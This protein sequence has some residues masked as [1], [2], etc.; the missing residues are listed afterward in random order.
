LTRAA[1]VVAL[2]VATP[3]VALGARAI[4]GGS[5]YGLHVLSMSAIYAIAVLG[6]QLVFGHAGAL[7]LSQGTFMGI[8]AYVGAYLGTRYGLS[9]TATLPLCVG[10]PVALAAIVGLPVMRL[11]THYFALATLVIAQIASL[12]ATQWESVSGGSNGI[13]GIPPLALSGIA[14]GRG[15]PTFVL[16]WGF[17]AVAA[18][19]TWRISRGKYG[20]ALAMMRAHPVAAPAIGIDIASL[21]FTAFLASA[22][23]AGLA[24][25]LYAPAIGVVSP[26]VLG[27]PLMVSLLT[28]AV[29]GSRRRIA[30][31]LAGSIL[32]TEL[33]EWFRFL[34]DD[35]LLAYGFALLVVIVLLPDGLVVAAEQWVSGIVPT[36]EPDRPTALPMPAAVRLEGG[37][38]EVVAVSRTFGGV[39]ALD[40]VSL[41]VAAGEVVGLIGPNGS[42]KT[43]L[44]NVVTGIVPAQ[45]GHI[46]LDGRSLTHELPHTIVRAGIARSFQ[47]PALIEDATALDNVALAHEPQRTTLLRA[48]IWGQQAPHQAS[49]RAFSMGLLDLLGAAASADLPCG[50]LSLAMRRRVEIAR[51][52]AGQPRLVLLDEPAA[53][54]SHAEQADLAQRLRLVAATGIGLLIIEHNQQ[55]LAS[56]CDR[57]IC[58]DAGRI[59]AAGRPAD[60]C[61]DPAVI[62]AYLGQAAAARG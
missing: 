60:V 31:A 10:V 24:G 20:M 3:C 55:F 18:V 58:L 6:Y 17:A 8:G 51:A 16:T 21:R 23:F 53:G 40:T 43:T 61:N 62:A 5:L 26:D 56:L 32:I 45:A 47:T 57:L 36:P 46:A 39:R 38:L 44:V 28:I 19:L 49:G 27:F 59:I 41:A 50:L 1:I 42:G 9:F 15:L 2:L 4:A 12:V 30:G 54:L 48:L 13:G 52:L 25:A 35:Y 7:A 11:R 14:I 37:L 22:G 29:I 33:P 34:R